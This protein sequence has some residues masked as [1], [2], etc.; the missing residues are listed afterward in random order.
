M[1]W[2]GLK[3]LNRKKSEEYFFRTSSVL[4]AERSGKVKTLLG[5]ET[6]VLDLKI[7]I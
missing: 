5:L 3:Y 1:D 7:R 6:P 4:K 2:G